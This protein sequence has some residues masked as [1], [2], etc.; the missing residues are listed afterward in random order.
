MNFLNKKTGQIVTAKTEYLIKMFERQPKMYELL[1]EDE[2]E[3][4]PVQSELPAGSQ[5]EP[6]V[7]P[8][9]EPAIEPPTDAEPDKGPAADTQPKRGR[10]PKGE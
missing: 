5:A 2:P 4:A 10:K 9:T 6:E 1:P 8:P 3:A 7:E